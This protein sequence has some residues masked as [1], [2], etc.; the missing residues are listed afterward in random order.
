MVSAISTLTAL[1]LALSACERLM[2]L[3]LNSAHVSGT[4]L[5]QQNK[6]IGRLNTGGLVGFPCYEILQNLTTTMCANLLISEL[7]QLE[8]KSIV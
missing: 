4:D 3:L 5:L 1:E 2:L 7:L 8:S 6:S